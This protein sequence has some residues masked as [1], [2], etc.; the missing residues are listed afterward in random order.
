[1]LMV[2]YISMA[3]GLLAL[4]AIAIQDFRDR[5]VSVG[6]LILLAT[7]LAVWTSLS[8]GPVE[9]LEQWA[10]NAFVLLVQLILVFLY[11]LAKTRQW[12]FFDHYLGWGDVVMLTVIAIPFSTTRFMVFLGGSLVAI[13]FTTVIHRLLSK[14]ENSVPLA[15]ALA[16][17]FVIFCA[18]SMTLGV[19]PWMEFN[20]LLAVQ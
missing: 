5:L 9:A 11:F 10:M 19:D 2:S 20:L 18:W 13:L 6:W 14:K 1:M 16:I 17:T 4:V 15:G 7:S 3:I 12:K 8:V